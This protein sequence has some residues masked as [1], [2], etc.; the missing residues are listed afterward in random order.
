V[1]QTLRTLIQTLERAASHSP[2][3]DR[4]EVLVEA[5][6]PQGDVFETKGSGLAAGARYD[7]ELHA[8]VIETK[9]VGAQD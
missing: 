9:E 7:L 8:I 3:V 5:P 2:L 6:H 1:S 4:T